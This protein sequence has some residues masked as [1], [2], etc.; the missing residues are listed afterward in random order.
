MSYNLC[1]VQ[2]VQ[3]AGRAGRTQPG[4]CY[5]LYT[6]K[7]FQ[8]EMPNVAVPEIQRTS[9]LTTVLSLK[10]LPLPVDVLAFDFL[11]APS[12]STQSQYHAMH[13]NLA[14]KTH[15]ASAIAHARQKCLHACYPLHQWKDV[16][17]I[18]VNS[19]CWRRLLSDYLLS[20]A[21]GVHTELMFFCLTSI[22]V[23]LPSLPGC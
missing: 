11:D 15:A 23:Y 12:V 3:R 5:R 18:M 17:Y 1:R 10:S 14:V 2:A 4:K 9:L 6:S 13:Q 20:A 22:I 8:Q 16:A 21:G 19:S 7:H